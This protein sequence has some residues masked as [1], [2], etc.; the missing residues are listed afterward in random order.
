MS[1]ACKDNYMKFKLVLE[2]VDKYQE[3][4]SSM[5]MNKY[6]VDKVNEMMHKL[7]GGKM[8]IDFAISK[9]ED[10]ATKLKVQFDEKSSKYFSK[11]KTNDLYF[12]SA[13]SLF[14]FIKDSLM[15]IYQYS[16]FKM[17]YNH[18][19]DPKSL[20]AVK[21]QIDQFQEQYP[22]KALSLTTSSSSSL[23]GEKKQSWDMVVIFRRRMTNLAKRIWHIVPVVSYDNRYGKI[24][25]PEE[26]EVYDKNLWKK[27]KS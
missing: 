1:F 10:E 14:D 2:T 18:M 25:E 5:R 23:K 27:R 16:D 8:L 24:I 11:G 26:Q 4:L 6:S 13:K 17:V 9:D 21:D 15:S 12:T 20:Q 3:K 22:N 7:D 19:F